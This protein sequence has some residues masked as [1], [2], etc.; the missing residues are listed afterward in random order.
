MGGGCGESR[1]KLVAPFKQCNN[2]TL[3]MQQ[4]K[5]WIVLGVSQVLPYATGQE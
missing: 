4:G 5:R 2:C 1:K 3:I